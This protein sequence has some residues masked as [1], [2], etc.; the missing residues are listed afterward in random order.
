LKTLLRHIPSGLSEGEARSGSLRSDKFNW[1][2]Y[3]VPLVPAVMRQKRRHLGLCVVKASLVY[4]ASPGQSRLHRETL[5]H[6]IKTKQQ[7]QN[8]I[9]QNKTK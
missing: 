9:K 3:D 4:K 7:Q 8:K 1:A 5:S 2:W 6:K